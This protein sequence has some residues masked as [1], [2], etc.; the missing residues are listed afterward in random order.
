M[1]G[2]YRNTWMLWIALALVAC[3]PPL[4]VPPLVALSLSCAVVGW[5]T[6]INVELRTLFVTLMFSILDVFFR[7]IGARNQYKVPQEGAPVLFVCAPHANQFLDPFVVMYGTGR[8]DVAFLAAAKSLRKRL[9]GGL[10]RLLKSIP[11]ERAQDLAFKGAGAVWL[12][13]EDGVSLSGRGTRFL[14]Q[15]HPSDSVSWGGATGRVETVDSD[16]RCTLR[17]PL[18]PPS[19]EYAPYK[20]LPHVDQS[21]MFT[22]VYSALL[23]GRA[24]G[25]FPEGGSHDRAS[26]LPLKAGIAIMALGA[27]T[28]HK[29]LPLRLV[30]VGLNYFSGHRFRGRVFLDLGEPFEVP[31]ELVALYAAGGQ[32]KHEATAKLM[33]LVE[34]ELGAV[35]VSAPD[36]ETL[37]FFWTLRRLTY[38]ADAAGH[39]HGHDAHHGAGASEAP[40]GGLG[41]RLAFVRKFSQGYEQLMADGTP[42]KE[43]ARV[44]HIRRLCSEYNE[45]LKAV[46]LRDYQ[47]AYVL[48]EL[49]R[50]R[51]LRLLVLRVALL[52]LY[53]ILLLPA[54]LFLPI[55][56]CTR[57]ISALKAAQALKGS[58]VKLEG[59][60]VLA[61]WKLM[62]SILLF[63]LLY[64]F[65]TVAIGEYAS[66]RLPPPWGL[67]SALLFFF[68]FPFLGFGAMKSGENTV[69]V[70]RSLV[71]L[72]MTVVRPESVHTF[73]EQRAALRLAM[74]GLVD[75][76]GW[77][78]PEGAD[79]LGA[80]S[81][82]RLSGASGAV[83]SAG[84]AAGGE[85][86][87]TPRDD[88]EL[89]MLEA[90]HR[91]SDK[92]LL[93]AKDMKRKSKGG[94]YARIPSAQQLFFGAKA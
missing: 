57:S 59:R 14:E 78:V 70:A 22:E 23:K 83:A 19:D 42:L 50:P 82:A 53:V 17:A 61:T 43:S 31:D 56:V 37:E 68:A 87:G 79:E 18:T 66:E 51:A 13:P 48:D 92:S 69:R 1:K 52:L 72:L 63:P 44:V 74:Q 94:L 84:G 60:D 90:L 85:T 81:P 86:D 20:V 7:E 77:H 64:V 54:A 88:T 16:E 25:I 46:G 30:P 4:D 35:T 32:S 6:L 73:V 80:D 27:L 24:V 40:G 62:V 49:S 36:Y 55:L 3:L 89:Q 91:A 47:V 45:R 39:G 34:E 75:E 10:A 21:L 71:P 12:S 26:L 28:R 76:H 8:S 33:A 15:L 38:N 93:G 58:S 11:V 2:G 67:E 9:V 65:Y 41:Q 29:G 5:W